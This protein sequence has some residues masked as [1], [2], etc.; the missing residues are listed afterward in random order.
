[1][2]RI[3]DFSYVRSYNFYYNHNMR[4]YWKIAA[5]SSLE[6]WQLVA[7]LEESVSGESTEEKW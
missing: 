6:I 5:L 3:W 1:M 7:R 4:C 2:S